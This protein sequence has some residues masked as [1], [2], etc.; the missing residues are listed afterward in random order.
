MNCSIRRP[1][2]V[3]SLAAVIVSV[4]LAGMSASWAQQPAP[5]E[6]GVKEASTAFYAALS[7]T[8]VAA[9]KQVWGH[10]PYVVYVGPQSKT[11]VRGWAAVEAAWEQSFAANMSRSVALT[12]ADILTDGNI[13]WEVGTETGT[14]KAKDGSERKSDN[15]VTNVY[16]NQ[17]GRWLMVSHHAQSK[18]Q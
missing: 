14:I 5:N 12:E 9:M 11:L 2:S 8:D 16:E 6:D 1:G 17:N 4:M 10:T 7:G 13:A 15:I 18:P 3:L